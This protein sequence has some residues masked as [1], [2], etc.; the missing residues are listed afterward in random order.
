MAARGG[1]ARQVP[2]HEVR[3][4]Q[5][6]R[7]RLARGL[8]IVP[9]SLVGVPEGVREVQQDG[10]VVVVHLRHCNGKRKDLVSKRLP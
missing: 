2:E 9:A 7:G 3:V 6:P 1:G 8:A 5:R 10:E 4:Q